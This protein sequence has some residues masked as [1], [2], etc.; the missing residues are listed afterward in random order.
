MPKRVSIYYLRIVHIFIVFLKSERMPEI[1]DWVLVFLREKKTLC[2]DEGTG[3]PDN[4][5]IS[6][7]HVVGHFQCFIYIFSS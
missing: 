1:I 7:V 6:I 3:C 4:L 5:T 2:P